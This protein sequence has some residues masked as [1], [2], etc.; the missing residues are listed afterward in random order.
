MQTVYN[1]HTA[2]G[3]ELVTI[4]GPLNAVLAERV[5]QHF[6]QLAAQGVKQVIVNLAQTPIIDSHGLA[7]LVAGYKMFGRNP[8]NFRLAGPQLQPRLVL[9]LT[10]FDQIFQVYEHVAAALEAGLPVAMPVPLFTAAAE[11][12]Q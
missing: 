5:R 12:V 11:T 4:N 7:A 1:T 10:G 9:E 2:A 3:I 6:S 8:D